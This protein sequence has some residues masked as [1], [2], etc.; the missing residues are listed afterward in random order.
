M[1]D[2]RTTIGGVANVDFLDLGIAGVPTRVDTGAKTSAVWASSIVESERSLNFTLFGPGSEWYTGKKLRVRRYSQR[3]V[4]SSNGTKE[5]RYVVRMLVRLGGRKVRASF[6]LADRSTQV[7]PILT[8]R[9]ILRG[10]FIVDVNLDAAAKL[11]PKTNPKTAS[12]EAGKE[13]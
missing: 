3:V 9:N 5:Q 13:N 8:G 1:V 2:K 10:K 7:Y 6:T 11:N 12:D 4:T